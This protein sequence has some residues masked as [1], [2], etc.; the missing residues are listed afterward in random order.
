MHSI[1]VATFAVLLSGILFLN[2]NLCAVSITTN[3]GIV[4][5]AMQ[6]CSRRLLAKYL[7]KYIKESGKLLGNM[8]K[9]CWLNYSV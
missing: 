9:L 2:N 4:L 1:S 3:T 5:K 7:L 6:V 8:K